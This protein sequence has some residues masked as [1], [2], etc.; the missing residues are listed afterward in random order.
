MARIVQAGGDYVTDGERRAAELL[1]TLPTSWVVI[2]N[3][4]L[5]TANNRS[6]E[7]DFIVIGERLIFAIDEKSWHGR[8]HG[9]DVLWVRDDGSS[10]RSPLDK[11]DYVAKVLAGHLRTKVPQLGTARTHVVVGCVLLS[12]TE[13]HP[14]IRDPRAAKGVLLPTN[15]VQTLVQRDATEGDPCVGTARPRIEKALVDLSDRP[16]VPRAIGPYAITDLVSERFGARVFHAHHTDGTP[17]ML[18]LYRIDHD[19]ALRTFYLREYDALV[20]LRST[21][22]TPE[23]LDHFSWSE[24]FLAVP[25][26]MPAGTSLS[27]L[28]PPDG[29]GAAIAELQL[30][31]NAFAALEKIHAHGITHRAITPDIVYVSGTQDAPSVMLTGFFAAKSGLTISGKLDTLEIDDAYVAPEIAVAGYEFAAPTSD[32]YSLALVFLERFSGIPITKLRQADGA[33]AIPPESGGWQYFPQDVVQELIEFFRSVL[34]DGPVARDGTEQERLTASECVQQLDDI[35]AQAR[36][37]VRIAQGQLLDRRYR[38]ERVL[39]TGASARTFLVTDT[40]ADGLFAVK[41]FLRPATMR[42]SGEARR[43]FGILRNANSP[44]LPRIFDLYPPENDVHVKME[45]IEGPTLREELSRY[46]GQG[47]RCY[48]LACDLL[49]ALEHLEQYELLHRDIKPENVIIREGSGEA[50]LIDFGIATTTNAQATMAGT[51]YYMPPEALMSETPPQT[52]DRYALGVLLFH[53]LTGRMP[54]VAEGNRFEKEPVS[55]LDFVPTEMIPLARALLRAIVQNPAE[56]YGSAATF[57]AALTVAMSVSPRGEETEGV[58]SLATLVNPWVDALRGVFRNSEQG[59]A[60]NRGLDTPFAWETYVPTA[61]DNVLLPAILADRPRVVFLSGNPGDGK[62]AF[63]AQVREE[64]GRRG[65]SAVADDA[66][67]WEWT[68]DEHTFRACYDASE[69]HEGLSADAQLTARLDGLQ[70]DDAP[71]ANRTVLVAINDGR[72]ADISERFADVFGW[73]IRAA[74][75]ETT[76]TA[77]RLEPGGVWLVDLKE[78]AFVG[79]SSE[80]DRPSLMRRVLKTFVTPAHW[81]ICDGCVARATC[82]IHGNARLLGGDEGTEVARRLEHALLLAHLRERRHV[83]MRDL[84][85]GLA[86]LITSDLGCTQVHAALGNGDPL[87]DRDY[88]HTAFVTPADGDLLLGDLTALDPA[89]VAQPALERFFYFR[90]DGRDAPERTATFRNGQD[91]PPG[92]DSVEWIAQVKRRLYFEGVEDGTPM[93]I[94][95]TLLPYRYAEAF[96]SLLS[97]MTNLA[98]A[99][100]RIAAGLGRSDGLDAA[101]VANGLSLR[102]AQSETNRLTVLKH[103]PLSDFTLTAPQPQGGTMVEA[104]PRALLLTHQ[105]SPARLRIALDLFELLMRLADG[106]EIESAELQPLLED[107]SAFKNI[108]QMSETRELVIIEGDQRRHRITQR[109]GKIVLVGDEHAEARRRA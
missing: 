5:P 52:A 37:D 36:T 59:N 15:L 19:E 55:T 61:L 73:I 81:E 53:A 21:G 103:F 27:A 20:A 69:A 51:P 83:T 98:D 63:L 11:I 95:R 6:F 62:T 49:S 77:E 3:K 29:A 88:W 60:D 16:K 18:T 92:A 68:W 4:V 70:G 106:L 78:R 39:G 89:R 86:Y 82:P 10:E 94:W 96:V 40:E 54:F 65:G 33:I 105:R 109:D 45:Y 74:R 100:P 48:R 46:V 57:R 8:I 38:V 93:V 17:R 76:D 13:E 85:S 66:S 28:P 41:Q 84:R 104:L 102:V 22:V 12:R 107:T 2:A 44:H 47:A 9:S 108:V 42:A 101:T 87:P 64:L 31:R 1:T 34:T 26:R 58:D 25:C 32:I 90:R 23:V 75:R 43:E 50:V 30:A 72:L 56:R 14:H 99:L 24:D 79:A 97:D 91:L 80:A 7:I 35:I 67:G 71:S